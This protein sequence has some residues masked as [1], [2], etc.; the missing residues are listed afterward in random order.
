MTTAILFGTDGSALTK[1]CAEALKTAGVEYMFSAGDKPMIADFEWRWRDVMAP[2]VV[3]QADF[4]FCCDYPYLIRE[5]L[6]SSASR[7][8][9]NLHP[10][11]LPH[12]RGRHSAFWGIMNRTPLGATIHWMD[13]TFDTGDVIAQATFEDDGLM[14]AQEVYDRQMRLCGDLFETWLPRI[15]DGTAPRTPQRILVPYPLG[16]KYHKAEEIGAATSFHGDD[17]I[18]MWKLLRLIRATS[19]GD[20][21]FYVTVGGVRYKVQGKV[22]LA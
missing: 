9:V 22:T 13:A 14:T 7:G 6:L 4:L 8:A 16:A 19:H 11:V 3:L 1:R 21:G 18:P 5:P 2:G 12:N 20:H 10:A 15:L 17:D